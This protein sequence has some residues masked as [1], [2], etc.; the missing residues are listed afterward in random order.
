TLT[1][2]AEGDFRN[3]VGMQDFAQAAPLN[4]ALVV[5]TEKQEKVE[6]QAYS[7]A[8][9]SQN[10]YL[11]CASAGLKTVVRAAFAQEPLAKA[12]KLG[13]NEKIMFVQTVGR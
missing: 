3:L 13:E 8:A 4:I 6:F 9:A 2:I 1:R 12:M 7:A 5:D 10:I 11:Y